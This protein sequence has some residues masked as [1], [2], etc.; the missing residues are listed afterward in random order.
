MFDYDLASTVLLGGAFSSTYWAMEAVVTNLQAVDQTVLLGLGGVMVVAWTLVAGSASAR[1][2]RGRN[3]PLRSSMEHVVLWGVG[4]GGVA[5]VT[6][7][8]LGATLAL[9]SVYTLDTMFWFGLLT[10]T[11]VLTGALLIGSVGVYGALTD[12]GRP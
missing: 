10:V 1:T 4:F 3:H 8:S 9:V 2:L 11:T 12:S 6:T 7:W 5:V